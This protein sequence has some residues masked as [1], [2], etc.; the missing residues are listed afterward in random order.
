[1][2]LLDL[3]Q[4][5]TFD[6]QIKLLKSRG[7]IINNEEK[8]KFILS[9]INYYRFSAYLIHLKK[10]DDTY[11]KNTTFEYVYNL[12]LFDKELRNLL[13]E[14]LENIEVSFRTYISYT[15]AIRH[16]SHG[17]LDKQCFKNEKYFELFINKLESE[18]NNH[19]NKLFIKHHNDKYNGILPVWVAVEIMS[20]GTLSKLYSNML[21]QDTTYIK[22]ELCSINPTLVNSW[23]HSLTHLR[24]VCAHY[25]RIYNVNF[26]PIKIKNSDRNYM[27]DDKEIFGYILAINHLTPDKDVWND[28]FIKLQTLFNKYNGY[29]DKKLLGFPD[30]WVGILSR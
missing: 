21:P 3:K 30:N 9:N 20:F 12:Y 4:P 19:K 8:A 2:T 6:E 23:L 18:K 28:L 16:G 22:K 27:L 7:L 11:K 15:L 17:Y 13:I 25:G 10:E 24:N 1:M 5:K 14:M 26:P 29:I